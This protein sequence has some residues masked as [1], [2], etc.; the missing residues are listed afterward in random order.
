LGKYGSGLDGSSAMILK[1]KAVAV[2]HLGELPELIERERLATQYVVGQAPFIYGSF[3]PEEEDRRSGVGQVV[4]P[5]LEG[6]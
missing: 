4:V 2:P 6:E 3:R 5:A 1:L